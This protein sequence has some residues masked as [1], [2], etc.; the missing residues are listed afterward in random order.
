MYIES[1]NISN[2]RTFRKDHIDFLHKDRKPTDE[3]PT[4]KLPNVNLLLGNNGLGKTT[5]LKAISLAAL[6]PAVTDSGIYP[7]HLIRREPDSHPSK[8]TK[9]KSDME[10]P[11]GVATLTAVFK[12]HPQDSV[13]VSSVESEITIS[14]RGDLE[15]LRWTHQD[16]KPWQPIFSFSSDAFFFVGYGATRRVEKRDQVDTAGR[17][18]SSFA[19]A[20]RIQSLFE[21]AYSLLPFSAWLPAIKEEDPGRYQQVIDV[22]NQMMGKGHYRFT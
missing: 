5:L 12:G 10:P 19:R 7:Y 14:Q 6:G 17:R 21:E 1:I 15:Q 13:P 9:I 22:V 2:F 11:A 20:Q 8:G 3:L 16:E 18:Q 4:P